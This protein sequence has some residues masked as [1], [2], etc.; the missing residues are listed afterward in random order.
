MKLAL[1]AL[2]ACAACS[3]GDAALREEQSKSRHYRDAYET[4]AQEVE[5]LKARI[6]DLEQQ[7]CR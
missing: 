3:H 1:V 6:A 2:L 4:R 5:E 7:N